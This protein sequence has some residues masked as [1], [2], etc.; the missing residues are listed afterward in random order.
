MFLLDTSV[1][2][3][4]VYQAHALHEGVSRWLAIGERYATCGLTQIG[5]FRLLLMDAPMHGCPLVVADAHSVVADFTRTD[6]HTFLSCPPISPHY[7]GQTTGNKAAF[8]DYLVQIARTADCT[9]VTLDRP[10]A[11]RW[12]ANTLLLQ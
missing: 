11:N 8:D 9:L 3:A 1:L 10:L 2:F 6:R 12:P 4:A 5:V 7:V